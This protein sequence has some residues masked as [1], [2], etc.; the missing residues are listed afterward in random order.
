MLL[1]LLA[2]VHDDG[3]IVVA[4]TPDLAPVLQDFIDDIGD[5]RV[6]LAPVSE[7]DDADDAIRVARRYE[8]GLT[9]TIDGGVAS[10]CYTLT[11]RDPTTEQED[12]G[13]HAVGGDVLGAQYALADA[14]EQRGYGFYHPEETVIPA[15]LTSTVWG[16]Y[17]WNGEPRIPDQ[18]VRGLDPHTL[19]PI[20]FLQDAWM[21][22]DDN[23]ERAER[24]VDWLVKNRGNQLQWPGLEDILT[25]SSDGAAWA[26]HTAALMDYAHERGVTTAIGIQLF[27][28]SNLQEAFDLI[29]D[30]EAPEDDR[31]ATMDERLHVLLHP[32]GGP[33]VAF[34]KV[35][36]SFGEFSG[37]DPDV[38]IDNVDL[39]AD[40][41]RGISAEE[42]RDIEPDATIHVGANQTVTYDDQE[43]LYY[44]LVKYADPTIVPYIHTV[45][46]YTLFDDAG[47]AYGH[48]DFSEHR[49]Y[50]EDRMD[51]G[52]PVAYFPESAYWCAFDNPVPLYMP[53]YIKSRFEDMKELSEAGYP[54]D[55]H[56]TFSSGWEWGYWQTDVAV[57]R[58]GW[59]LPETWEDAVH[60][61]FPSLPQATQ[62]G[63][64]AL[65]NL[66]ESAL[67]VGRLAPWMA[68]RDAFMDIGR[69]A[70]IV[71]QP[72]RPTF[73]EIVAMSADDRAAFKTTVVEPLRQLGVDTRDLLAPVQA[74]SDGTVW[75]REVEDGI[76]IDALRAEYMTAVL[77]AVLAYADGNGTTSATTTAAADIEAAES[78]FVK[79]QAVV[80]RRHADLHD[81]D[82]TR[83]TGL[84]ENPTFYD[85]GYLHHADTLCFWQRDD[86]QVRNL[87]LGEANADP[88]CTFE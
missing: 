64:I 22:G 37:E 8:N 83:L 70:G 69:S 51:A 7:D 38:F 2:C 4:T 24:V 9:V 55:Q 73:D 21:P 78:T 27:G 43:I 67:I 72:D 87:V 40:V 50:L 56:V 88:G 62:D 17:D 44:F 31:R 52:Q 76:E 23:L 1:L 49:Q 12:R 39:F 14:L 86:V 6:T 28:G 54:L 46:Y 32:P 13:F 11:G 16:P 36:L 61:D 5:P 42:G 82:P 53:V 65:G 71:G 81:P 57:L 26:D 30:P 77:D 41:L 47:G 58:M 80:A 63:I 85:Y 48:D 34:D 74:A 29:D 10:G 68:G 25:S 3:G 15:D 18:S 84:L 60:A 19:H 35:N 20:E 75:Q 33:S 79:A 66:Q 45:M 59:S